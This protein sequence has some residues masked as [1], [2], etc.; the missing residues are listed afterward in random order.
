MAIEKLKKNLVKFF[1]I[2]ECLLTS[3]LTN[4]DSQLTWFFHNILKAIRESKNKGL[5]RIIFAGKWFQ[6]LLHNKFSK[7][8]SRLSRPGKQLK[9]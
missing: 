3:N 7:K 1:C 4:Q 2:F 6:K 8:T 5:K 9:T